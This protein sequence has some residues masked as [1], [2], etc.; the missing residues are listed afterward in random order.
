MAHKGKTWPLTTRRDFNLNVFTYQHGLPKTWHLHWGN[1]F[2]LGGFLLDNTDWICDEGPMPNEHTL[3]WRSVFTP[4]FPFL[5]RA[6]VELA[7]TGAPA[8][9]YRRIYLEDA[10]AGDVMVVR[11]DHDGLTQ[12]WREHSLDN[13]LLFWAPGFFFVRPVNWMPTYNPEPY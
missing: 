10:L 8:G 9:A 7:I 3:L 5:I 12:S 11:W 1:F 4:F 6:R 13:E 2:L